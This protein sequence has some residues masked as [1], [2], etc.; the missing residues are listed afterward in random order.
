MAYADL[1]AACDDLDAEHTEL[2]ATIG[3]IDD[4][5]WTLPTPSEPWTLADQVHHLAFWDHKAATAVTDP[6][7]FEA[8]V[9]LAAADPDEFLIDYE[10]S[11]RQDR[12]AMV[13][14]WRDGRTRVVAAAR[15]I[16][17]G[18]RVAVYGPAM[19]A[20][21]VA[22]A[23]LMEA[24][25]HGQDIRDTLGIER[26]PAAR[27]R[28]VAH[29]AVLARPFN[30]RLHGRE[31]PTS[32]IRVDLTGPNGDTWGWGDPG[33]PD[34]VSGDVLDFCLV[35]CQR[36]HVAD[37]G[38]RVDGPAAVEWMAIAQAFAGPPGQGRKRGQF[39]ASAAAT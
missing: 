26:R 29:L 32:P 4:R 27:L 6:E 3:A 38:L 18:R 39:R 22:S 24:F 35:V 17:E 20:V 16:A 1:A 28:H 37:T 19:G 23:R 12:E 21:S 7:A 2:D 11:R 36:R 33:S 34:G 9:R 13:A 14:W 5:S 10:R 30:Y 15:T 31:M 8:E 25:A